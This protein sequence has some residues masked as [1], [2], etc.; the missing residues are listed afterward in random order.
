[1]IKHT[2]TVFLLTISQMSKAITESSIR[3]HCKDDKVL[4]N[5]DNK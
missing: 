1:M 5:S 3:E 4:L 2:K